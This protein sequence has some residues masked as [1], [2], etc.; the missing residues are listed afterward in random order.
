MI[1]QTEPRRSPEE[2]RLAEE[3]E[4]EIGFERARTSDNP[5]GIYANAH[6]C[7]YLALYDDYDASMGAL[8]IQRMDDAGLLFAYAKGLLEGLLEN[9]TFDPDICE[10]R[11]PDDSELIEQ[12][13]YD[14]DLL[15]KVHR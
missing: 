11:D 4:Y 15:S 2:Q 1:G 13:V 6:R 12:E 3:R 5:G 7:Q 8:P 9:P 14:R 10:P